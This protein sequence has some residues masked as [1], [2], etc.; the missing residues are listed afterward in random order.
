ML[1]STERNIGESAGVY[2]KHGAKPVFFV[3]QPGPA[4]INTTAEEV[5][6]AVARITESE[7]IQG[8]HVQRAGN[9]WRIYTQSTEDRARLLTSGISLQGKHTTLQDI[10][11]FAPKYEGTKVTIHGIHLSVSDTVISLTLRQYGCELTSGV[12]R[13][14]L[15]V[16]GKLTTCQTGARTVFV[17]LPAQPLPKMIEMGRYRGT[18][19]YQ[20][21]E[22]THVSKNVTCR[23]CLLPGH[24]AADCR[25]NWVCSLCRKPGHKR[26]E[27]GHT[28][29]SP[30]YGTDR[31]NADTASASTNT[32]LSGAISKTPEPKDDKKKKKKK[33]ETTPAPGLSPPS[34]TY[35]D[36]A[37][38]ASTNTPLSGAISKTPVPKEEKKK[39]ETTPAPGTQK[40]TSFIASCRSQSEAAANNINTPTEQQ[41][42]SRYARSPRTPPEAMNDYERL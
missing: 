26:Q 35:R 4:R 23:K 8:I 7:N 36:N 32:P 34:G 11:P 22:T 13:Q 27:C 40:I 6:R 1:E 15:R 9:L 25:N 37:D 20:G 2:S 28:I 16:D 17:K 21:Q 24:L 30:P 14:L 29:L 19:Y 41:R 38:T 33:T 31:D 10:N 5:Y 3:Q 18:V 39:K 12:E 42:K